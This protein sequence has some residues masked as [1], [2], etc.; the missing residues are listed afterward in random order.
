MTTLNIAIIGAGL[1]GRLLA[2]QLSRHSH[3]VSLFEAN[4]INNTLKVASLSAAAF[5]AAGMIA[6]ISET[7]ESD[8]DTFDLGKTSLLLWPKI[9]AQLEISCKENLYYQHNG[10]LIICHPQDTP[11]LTHFR[12]RVKSLAATSNA[13][14]QDLNAAQIQQLEP[15]LG[16]GFNDGMLL[17]DEANIDNRHLMAL[18]LKASIEQGVKLIDNTPAQVQNNTVHHAKGSETFDWVFD[19]RGVGAKAQLSNLRGVRG[20][21]LR[22]HC[23]EVQLSRP[24]RLMH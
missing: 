15:D 19:C 5:T 22:V 13:Q 7:L 3:S 11:E 18:L 8:L 21:V 17:P 9:I 1:V 12:R 2:H 10:S 4:Q 6:P 20:E 24:V 23:P 16:N 14:Y